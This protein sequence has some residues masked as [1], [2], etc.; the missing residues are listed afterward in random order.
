MYGLIGSFKAADGRR[1]DLMK[2]LLAEASALPGCLSYVV[3]EDPADEVTVWV[4]E[5]W[6]DADAHKASLQLPAVKAVIAQAMPLIAAFG[7]HRVTRPVGG[8]AL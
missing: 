4:T 8:H 3:A 7:E 5:V 1:A 2:L 6:T